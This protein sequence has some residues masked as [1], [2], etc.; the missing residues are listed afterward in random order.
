M[1]R[2]LAAWLAIL[3]LAGAGVAYAEDVPVQPACADFTGGGGFTL[4]NGVVSGSLD[5][6]DTSCTNIRYT[7]NVI[8]TNPG[9]IQLMRSQSVKGDGTSP[10]VFFSLRLPPSVTTVETY[11]E[12]TDTAGTVLDR[13]PDT[14]TIS[15]TSGSGGGSGYN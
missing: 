13:G 6:A 10:I 1:K 9:G 7:L 3:S 4:E 14:G 8:Y 12:S 15:V 2:L 11:V 5:L